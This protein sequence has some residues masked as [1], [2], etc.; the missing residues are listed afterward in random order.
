MRSLD[1]LWKYQEADMQ[2]LRYENEIR[3]DPTRQ[4]LLKLRSLVSD[5]QTI[6]KGLET[7]TEASA[8]KIDEY[9]ELDSKLKALLEQ[10]KDRLSEE[11][12]ENAASVRQVIGE[13]QQLFDKLKTAEK[14]LQRMS[15]YSDQV[16]NRYREIRKKIQDSYDQYTKLKAGYDAHYAKQVA[17]LDELKQKRDQLTGDVDADLLKRYE[18]I[19]S[20][21]VPVM[22]RLIDSQC[23]GCNI[24]LPVAVVEACKSHEHIVECENCG[25]ILYYQSET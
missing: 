11:D 10:G 15:K 24:S 25:R 2:V 17:K 6:L 7:E 16:V 22:A 21:R 9:A 12:Y 5:Q 8:R 23:G 19:K 14:D 1:N 18:T 3:R 4:K 20:Q 13:V